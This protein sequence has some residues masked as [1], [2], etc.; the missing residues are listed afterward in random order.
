MANPVRT[1]VLN[2][3]AQD[4]LDSAATKWEDTERAWIAIEWALA[5]DPLVGVPLNEKGNVRGLVYDGARSISQPDVSVIYEITEHEIIVQDAV[6]SDAK[7]SQ[8]GRG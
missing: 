7:A 1:V 6:F 4:A 3:A 5:H 2:A 8:A